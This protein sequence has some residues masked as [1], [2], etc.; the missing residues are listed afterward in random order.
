MDGKTDIVGGGYW[1]K[2]IKG[3]KFEAHPIDS[4]YCFTRTAVGD[5]IRGGRPEV[6]LC[7]GDGVGPLNLYEWKDGTWQTNTLIDRVDHG[8]TLQVAD[9]NNDGNLDIYAAEMFDPGLKDKCRQW[10]LYR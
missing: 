7:S 4:G 3:T 1:F 6:V 2:H 8:H 5:L 9:I 10:V